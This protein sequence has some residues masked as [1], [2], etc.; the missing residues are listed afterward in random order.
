M[1]GPRNDWKLSH[2]HLSFALL[3]FK[4]MS[5]PLA[6]EDSGHFLP[7]ES[8]RISFLL[9]FPHHWL[10]RRPCRPPLLLTLLP[11]AYNI[12]KT[13][14]N[15]SYSERTDGVLYWTLKQSG[16]VEASHTCPWDAG[17]QLEVSW[18]W[19]SLPPSLPFSPQDREVAID[20]SLVI[21]KSF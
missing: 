16:C 14:R 9:Y 19:K 12:P 17:C 11:S 6:P 4:R 21:I 7:L 5:P 13:T 8:I 1:Q 20:N 2:H 3:W 10:P 18:C 15:L